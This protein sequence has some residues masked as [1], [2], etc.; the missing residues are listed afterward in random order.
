MN[1]FSYLLLVLIH[2][3][4]LF[5]SCS[6]TIKSKAELQAYLNDQDNGLT[7]TTQKSD[8]AIKM[9]W[10]PWQLIANKLG[11]PKDKTNTGSSPFAENLYFILSLSKGNKELLRQLPFET[12]SEMVQ[13]LSFR[14]QNFI[15]A[16]LGKTSIEPVECVFQ[17]TYGMTEAN[18]LLLVFNKKDVGEADNLTISLK[19]FG[20]G[21]GNLE[22]PFKLKNINQIEKLDYGKIL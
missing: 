6:P 12:Y 3:T 4:V 2:I 9:T 7:E 19:E 20:L 13:V 18:M 21:L 15:S 5:Q 1:R 11:S 22:F 14:M 10:Q 17:Q 16:E 8:V